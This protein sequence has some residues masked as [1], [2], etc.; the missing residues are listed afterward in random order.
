MSVYKQL[1]NPLKNSRGL[2]STR[3]GTH[4][5]WAQRLTAIAL[6]LFTL[7]LIPSMLKHAVYAD[8]IHLQT[9]M[10]NAFNAVGLALMIGVLFYHSKLGLQVVIEDYVTCA[11][12]KTALLIGNAFFCYGAGALSILSII[13]LHLNS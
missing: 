11:C 8:A 1:R 7:W 3:D 9:W 5:W 2:G 4:H 13:K 6:V 12:G 10:G